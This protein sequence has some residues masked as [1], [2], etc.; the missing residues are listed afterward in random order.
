MMRGFVTGGSGFIGTNLVQRLFDSGCTILNFDIKPPQNTEHQPFWVKGDVRDSETLFTELDKFKPD[1]LIHLAART[2]LDGIDIDEYSTNTDGVLN[3][4]QAI[5]KLSS[6]EKVLFASSRLVCKIGYQPKT[7][8]DYCPTTFYGESK[9]IGEKIVKEKADTIPCPWLI[10]RPTSIWGPWFGTPYKEFFMSIIH[11]HYIHPKNHSIKKSFGYVG[12]TVYSLHHLIQHF[13]PELNK[14]T[15]YL[16]DY[17]PIDVLEWANQI[18]VRYGRKPPRE[19]DIKLL[20]V[21]AKSGDLLKVLGYKNPPLTS[22]RLDN[23]LTDMIHDTSE[24]EKFCG[25]LPFTQSEGIHA[26]LKWLSQQC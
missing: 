19:V 14:K 20:E 26:T 12:N 4:V 10:F 13:S 24:L 5:A 16:C 9:M 17:Q 23:L 3:I 15:L 2:D 6:L 8:D 25:P 1:F 22:F 18:A 21:L 11:G 7:E